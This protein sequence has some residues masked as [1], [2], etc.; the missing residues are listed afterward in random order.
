M[1][2]RG[3]F[4]G[5]LKNLFK[6]GKTN[7]ISLENES[8]EFTLDV[9]DTEVVRVGVGKFAVTGA[10]SSST[11]TITASADNIDVSGVNILFINPSA[12]VVIGGFTG[13]VNGQVLHLAIIAA[14]ENV[15]LEHLEG[16]GDQDVVL[17]K[18]VDE[19]L[20]SEYGGWVL[21]CD[22][23]YWYDVSHAQHV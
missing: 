11:L 6:I 17:H 3:N 14:A 2:V 12:A 10:I 5:T 23:S 20:A 15:T 1:A 7:P 22:G 19:T 8:G 16:V 4:V 21:A 18:G 13:G 9:L